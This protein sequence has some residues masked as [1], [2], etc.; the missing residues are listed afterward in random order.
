MKAITR[1]AYGQTDVVELCDVET[2]TPKDDEI[3]IRVEAA[4]VGR[5]VWHMMTGDPYIMRL[6]VG[7]RA[8]RSII[9]GRD[10]AGYVEAVGR[11]ATRFRPGEAVMGTSGGGTFAEYVCAQESKVAPRPDGVTAEQAAAIPIS[12]STAL[13]GLRDRGRIGAGQEVLVVGASGGVGTFAVQIAKAYGARVTGVCSGAKAE[14]VRS[15]GVDR[16]VDHERES[17]ADIGP[18]HDLILDIGGR[19]SLADLRRALAPDGT[20]VLAGGEGGDRWTGGLGRQLRAVLTSPFLRQRLCMFVA[21][22]N[23]A[24]LERLTDMI[25]A[26]QVTPVVDGP[27]PLSDAAGAIRHL[28]AG[29]GR[30]KVVVSVLGPDR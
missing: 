11:D 30:G 5:D 19:S 21:R 17:F 22:E 13:Q 2:P 25:D 20:L 3:L 28:A 23:S 12:G 24:D 18:V 27:Y 8:P 15:L 29:R 26:G 7:L 14:M 9:L 1:R 10:F 4:G 16:V 6:A